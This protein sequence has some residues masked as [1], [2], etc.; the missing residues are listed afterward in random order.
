MFLTVAYITDTPEVTSLAG[1]AGKTSHLTTA[2]GPQFSNPFLHPPQTANQII[3]DL[4]TLKSRVDP[5]DLVSYAR[6]SQESFR[7]NGV[8]L[9]FWRDWALPTGLLPD[10]YRLFPIEVLHHFHKSF[11]D[12]TSSG[13]YVHWERGRST[14]DFRFCSPATDSGIFHREYPTSNK[15]PVG[16]TVTY[17]ATFLV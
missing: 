11:W 12:M 9:P 2:F 14:S 13:V 17:N 10:P 4:S 16:S 7:L 1:V 5:W 3:T 6:E 8:D 15:S